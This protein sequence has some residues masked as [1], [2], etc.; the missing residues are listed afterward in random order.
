M[1]IQNGEIETDNFKQL[2]K[3]RNVRFRLNYYSGNIILPIPPA[4][5]RLD[6]Q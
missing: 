5:I 4:V 2:D 6:S 3:R 1:G